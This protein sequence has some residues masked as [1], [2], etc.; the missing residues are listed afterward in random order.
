MAIPISVASELHTLATVLSI[1][2]H[3]ARGELVITSE[4]GYT[5]TLVLDMHDGRGEWEI[6]NEGWL[7]DAK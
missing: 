5:V 4:D 6:V 1:I 7:N 3:T 2:V